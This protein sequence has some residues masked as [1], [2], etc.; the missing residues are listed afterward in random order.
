LISGL[1]PPILDESGI[2]EAVEYLVHE[3]REPGGPEIVFHHDVQTK[4]LAPPLESALFRIAQELLRNARRHSRSQTI[5]VK[6]VERDGRVRLDVRDWGIGFQ[7]DAV[8]QQR[9]GLQG[10]RERVR[11]LD[12]RMTIESA[13]DKGTHVSVEL[14]LVGGD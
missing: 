7:V 10:V 5:H 9:F 2:V 4:R 1:R 6:L 3:Q 11:L 14:P 8:A 13:P 12:G